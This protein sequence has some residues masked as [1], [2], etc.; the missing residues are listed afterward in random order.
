MAHICKAVIDADQAMR[1]ISG[2]QRSLELALNGHI[3]PEL[4]WNILSMSRAL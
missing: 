4:E 3:V 2:H 1:Q